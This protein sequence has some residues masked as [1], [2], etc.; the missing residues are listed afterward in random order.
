T[1]KAKIRSHVETVTSPSPQRS[2]DHHPYLHRLRLAKV[3]NGAGG[4]QLSIELSRLID[5]CGGSTGERDKKGKI[6]SARGSLVSSGGGEGGGAAAAAA[7]ASAAS[8]KAE[9]SSQT[10]RTVVRG[11]II[12]DARTLNAHPTLLSTSHHHSTTADHHH[13]HYHYQQ[14]HSVVAPSQQQQQ[15][16]HSWCS[17]CKLATDQQQ[18][19]TTVPGVVAQPPPVVSCL[20]GVYPG[21]PTA[22][23][24]GCGAQAGPLVPRVPPPPA[25]PQP[26]LLAGVG[27]YKQQPQPQSIVGP[28]SAGLVQTAA[29]ANVTPSGCRTCCCHH[30]QV[31]PQQQQQPTQPQQ[32]QHHHHHHHQPAT[33]VQLTSQRGGIS[34]R[35]ARVASTT[36]VRAAPYAHSQHQVLGTEC[37][38]REDTGAVG[39]GGAAHILGG[40]M[41]F[42]PFTVPSF[43][44]THQQQQQQ[45]QQSHPAVVATAPPP[46]AHGPVQS[47]HH[48]AVAV[49]SVVPAGPAGQ[50]QIVQAQQQ[51][52]QQGQPQ[53]GV[54]APG[55]QLNHLSHQALV[56]QQQQQQQTPTS[57]QQPI[58]HSTSCSPQ[59]QATTPNKAVG[60]RKSARTSEK[61]LARAR[62]RRERD[63]VSSERVKLQQSQRR[64]ASHTCVSHLMF[65]PRARSAK[66]R[67]HTY[68]ICAGLQ[69]RPEAHRAGL[70]CVTKIRNRAQQPRSRKFERGKSLD[71]SLI[72]WQQLY[73]FGSSSSSSSF[74]LVH[75]TQSKDAPE[76][77]TYAYKPLVPLQ[78]H[79]N[80]NYTIPTATTTGTTTTTAAAAAAAETK[81]KKKAGKKAAAATREEKKYMYKYLEYQRLVRT[82]ACTRFA[83]RRDADDISL[84][85]QRQALLSRTTSIRSSDLS[86]L[87]RLLRSIVI[88]LAIFGKKKIAVERKSPCARRRR[89]SDF[90]ARCHNRIQTSIIHLAACFA[91][92]R[93]V[94]LFVCLSLHSRAKT[95]KARWWVL[96]RE[97][98]ARHTTTTTIRSCSVR[99]RERERHYKRITRSIVLSLSLSLCTARRLT[100][101]RTAYTVSRAISAHFSDINESTTSR[102]TPRRHAKMVSLAMTRNFLEVIV[103]MRNQFLMNFAENLSR[104][105]RQR[106]TKNLGADRIVF[107]RVSQV[108]RGLSAYKFL[109]VR[110]LYVL[111]SLRLGSISSSSIREYK[112]PLRAGNCTLQKKLVPEIAAA[113]LLKKEERS[114][115]KEYEDGRSIGNRTIQKRVNAICEKAALTRHDAR[116]RAVHEVF[117]CK[118]SA[119]IARTRK[120]QIVNPTKV[121]KV[122]LSLPP[123]LRRKREIEPRG[124]GNTER[125]MTKCTYDDGAGYFY[126]LFAL[127]RDALA[128]LMNASSCI[129][130]YFAATRY[131]FLSV[132]FSDTR[133][134]T[135]I[136][137]LANQRSQETKPYEK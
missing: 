83:L 109:T 115:K 18:Q 66:Q 3:S 53:P 89:D 13:L 108:W 96:Q 113:W 25:P 24:A 43:P 1:L 5:D 59:Q 21:A 67:S 14:H 88:F 38:C 127:R 100:W 29:A 48:T 44:A 80:Y 132:S 105:K 4:L 65:V 102:I 50:N 49:Q 130:C 11:P 22:P 54:V 135:V 82:L 111:I 9:A 41:L 85:L 36:S 98:R 103:T 73:N 92:W 30:Q 86:A 7:A 129:G 56:Q 26:P 60:R 68:T 93:T 117:I 133:C 57:Q 51:Q 2:R 12:I 69:D 23:T 97:P 27:P 32:Q 55:A 16:Q 78:T 134:N 121:K 123:C 131:R 63:R 19:Q 46:L 84:L 10:T 64:S 58:I 72:L 112:L 110:Y 31:T 74:S 106:S 122:F 28:V 35:V 116:R 87:N 90:T 125:D 137:K 42:V 15:Q 47:H 99:D 37:R 40:P 52:Q 76:L 71:Q 118:P 128:R 126:T 34:L 95:P 81:K 107:S 39:G 77:A 136:C 6:P 114:S 33:A 91:R 124:E 104:C 17:G 70:C 61:Q 101:P 75:H 20:L 120:C 79:E 119:R 94:V 8:A 62:A 45:Q